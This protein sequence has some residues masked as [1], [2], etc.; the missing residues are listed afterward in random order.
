MVLSFLHRRLSIVFLA[1]LI[2]APVLA[3]AKTASAGVETKIALEESLERRLKSVISQILG[4]NDVIVIVKAEMYTE[5]EKKSASDEETVALPGVPLKEKIGERDSVAALDIGET[6]TLIKNLSATLVLDQSV[7]EADVNVIQNVTTGLLGLKEERGDKLEIQR[8][9]FRRGQ[10]KGFNWK[11][12]LT[13]PDLWWTMGLALLGVFI[14]LMT[15]FFFGSFR[16][17]I[18]EFV[19]ALR[20]YGE[21]VE[22]QIKLMQMQ[23]KSQEELAGRGPEAEATR[24]WDTVLA[25]PSAG[26]GAPGVPAENGKNGAP[27]SFLNESHLQNL[28]F[29]LQREKPEQ[30]ALV[31]NYLPPALANDVM[32]SLEPLQQSQVLS[33]LTRVADME[34]ETVRAVEEKIR[35]RVS[36][37]VGGEEKLQTLLDEADP[38]TQKSMLAALAQ[39]DPALADRL[40]QK[41]FTLEDL[42]ALDAP[43]LTA[44]VRRINTRALA[45]VLHG[46][47]PAVQEKILSSLPPGSANILREEISLARPLPPQRLAQ[48]QKRILRHIRRLQEE[49]VIQLKRGASV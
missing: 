49:G 39:K 5:Q 29:L 8:M 12:L 18:R 44:I 31:V 37:V 41:L 1:V 14:L 17:F 36:F 30:V 24:E 43:A 38:A 33:F 22:E 23:K 7:S 40:R 2:L 13:P 10:P 3:R 35:E 27:F 28:K 9:D 19:R 47:S 34:P 4:T 15:V 20:N 25:R 45:G 21:S 11:R 42:G 16:V 32:A 46:V 6:R 26:N 48:E